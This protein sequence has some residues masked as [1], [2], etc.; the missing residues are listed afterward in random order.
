MSLTDQI[1]WQTVSK[2]IIP[3]DYP[4]TNLSNGGTLL[5]LWSDD[6]VFSE[7]EKQVLSNELIFETRF[8]VPGEI[9]CGLYYYTDYVTGSGEISVEVYK[10][11]VFVGKGTARG[12][13]RV[14]SHDNICR[15]NFTHGDVIRFFASG[16]LTVPGL[17]G[18]EKA[19]SA[20]VR[21]CLIDDVSRIAIVS[22]K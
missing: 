8:L 15:V 11:D 17:S 7:T 22:S 21:G 20:F 18:A 9:S 4:Q 6:R 12:N 10:N 5:S 13:M 16:Y 14:N 1:I 19:I 2:K 3:L